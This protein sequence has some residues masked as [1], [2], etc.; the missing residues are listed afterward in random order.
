MGIYYILAIGQWIKIDIYLPTNQNTTTCWYLDAS[1]FVSSPDQ[2]AK[3]MSNESCSTAWFWISLPQN[4]EKIEEITQRSL[5]RIWILRTFFSSSVNSAWQLRMRF[6]CFGCDN[7]ISAVFRGFQSYRL[8]DSSRRSS[9][10]EC[11]TS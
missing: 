8:A 11:P 4:P 6:R 10:E 7:N 3:S 5:E 9:N 1:S 2:G